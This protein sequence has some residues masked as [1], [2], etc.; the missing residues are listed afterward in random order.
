MGLA[1]K[2]CL[3]A[4]KDMQEN[5]DGGGGGGGC[6]RSLRHILHLVTDLDG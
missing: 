4:L 5:N 3:L 6:L 1:L 2:Q